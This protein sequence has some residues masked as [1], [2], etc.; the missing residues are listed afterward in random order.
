MVL[1]PR[2]AFFGIPA[3]P[4]IVVPNAPDFIQKDSDVGEFKKA[5]RLDTGR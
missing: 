2:F 4:C 5:E 1:F 3:L